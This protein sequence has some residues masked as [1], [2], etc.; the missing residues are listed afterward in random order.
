M[1]AKKRTSKKR[2]SKKPTSRTKTSKKPAGDL[3]VRLSK[4]ADARRKALG[5]ERTTASRDVSKRIAA[6]AKK[7]NMIIEWSIWPKESRDTADGGCGCGCGCGC[8][9]GCSC[10]A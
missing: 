2:T 6:L 5:L 7:K 4:A 8:T 1:A 9:C 10:V 3:N